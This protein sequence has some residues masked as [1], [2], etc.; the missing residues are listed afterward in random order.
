MAT[1]ITYDLCPQSPIYT[2][3]ENI[4]KSRIGFSERFMTVFRISQ[5][6][7]SL[8]DI[9]VETMGFEGGAF[10]SL[11]SKA[12]NYGWGVMKNLRMMKFQ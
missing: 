6:L 3:F 11:G 7:L 12:R 8:L 1:L 5:K 2:V 4:K 10:F 9:H